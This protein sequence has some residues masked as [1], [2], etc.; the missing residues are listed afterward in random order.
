MTS[1]KLARIAQAA[2]V[3]REVI[4]CEFEWE[5]PGHSLPYGKGA[6]MLL[7]HGVGSSL[8]PY[9]N[10][11]CREYDKIEKMVDALSAIG[12]YVEDCTGDYSGVYEVTA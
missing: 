4:G 9:C 2:S 8:R 1:D 11:D 10:Y 7:T 6:V 12:L 5:T 3:I